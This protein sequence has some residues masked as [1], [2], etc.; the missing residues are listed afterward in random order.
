MAQKPQK[1]QKKGWFHGLWETDFFSHIKPWDFDPPPPRDTC[2]DF[3]WVIV[4]KRFVWLQRTFHFLQIDPK[5]FRTNLAPETLKQDFSEIHKENPDFL[6]ILNFFHIFHHPEK[7]IRP[8]HFKLSGDLHIDCPELLWK[9]RPL[10]SHRT[11]SAIFFRNITD[12][13]TNHGLTRLYPMWVTWL[14]QIKFIRL[15][16]PYFILWEYI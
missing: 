9:F 12:C 5:S 2:H 14:D 15:S 4:L 3:Y 8:I 7:T 16:F 13:R 10:I 1:T 11:A 6:P